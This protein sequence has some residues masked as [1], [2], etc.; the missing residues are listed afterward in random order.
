MAD[1][2]I[3]YSSK[4]REKADQLIELLS[5]AGLSVWI[6]RQGIDVATSWSGEIVDAIDQCKALVVLLSPAS[7]ASKNVVREVA[8]AFE[9]NKKIFPLDLEPVTL[10]R[11]L[12]YHL[13]GIQRASIT[14]V[15]SI[16]RTLSKL[17]TTAAPESR[18]IHPTDTRKSLMILPFEDLSPTRDNEWFTDG[19][20]SELVHVL[21]NVKT[22][23]IIDWNTSKLFKERKVKTVDLAR[24]L[25]VR[26]FIEGQVRKFG[27]Q[28]KI[29]ATLLDIET[30][31][32]LWQDG[33][34]GTMDDIFDIQEQVAQKVLNGLKVHL[35]TEEER[36]VTVRPTQ[37]A[38]AY[39]LWLKG[40]EHFNHQTKIDF[41]RALTLFGEA[42]KLDPL[43]ARAHAHMANALAAMYRLYS[44]NTEWLDR[45]E[46]A[47]AKVLE[48]EGESAR[49]AWVMSRITLLRGDAEAALN[50]AR[51][52]IEIDPDYALGFDAFGLACKKLGDHEGRIWACREYVRLREDE[53]SPYWSLLI[54][55][56]E[57]GDEEKHREELRST[58]ER[59]LPIFERQTRLNPDDYN[60]SVQY[61]NVLQMAG[62]VEEALQHADTLS[63]LE[64]LDASSCYNLACMYLRANDRARGLAMFRRTVEKGYVEIELFR[65]DPDLDPLRGTPEFE[66][67]L[68]ELEERIAREASS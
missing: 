15:E 11:D 20:A 59:A 13:A 29:A 38:E 6:D 31:D 48:L 1:I 60:V 43:F 35:A 68:K 3:S 52:S 54:A 37:N 63:R 24:E 21:S 56:G 57:L 49:Y 62:R 64:T 50:Y 46:Q 33:F 36:I 34:K 4:D 32:H 66:T 28:I 58:A 67:L 16:I 17:G 39:A 40:R 7:V 27:D 25:D 45:A 65:H 9:K 12:Q 61:A 44:R 23:R 51:R 30:A 41:E 18:T 42:V 2:F 10:T 53:P 5:S 22:L 8:L 47:A 19:I 55:L 26:Y 14:N